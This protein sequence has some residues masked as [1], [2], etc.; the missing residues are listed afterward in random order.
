MCV[1]LVSLIETSMVN[2]VNMSKDIYVVKTMRIGKVEGTKSMV[3]GL[4]SDLNI[5]NLIEMVISRN[6][7]S[8]MKNVIIVVYSHNQKY[9]MMTMTDITTIFLILYR[10]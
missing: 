7:E 8:S 2:F 6:I 5:H 3:I 10:L 9:I 1:E 4:F